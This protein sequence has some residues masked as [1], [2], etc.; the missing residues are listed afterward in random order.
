MY[1]RGEH[2]LLENLSTNKNEEGILIY[3][4]KAKFFN[5]IKH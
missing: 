4:S 2:K 5:T 3:E 1:L